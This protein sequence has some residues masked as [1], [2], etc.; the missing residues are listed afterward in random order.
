VDPDVSAL[1]LGVRQAVLDVGPVNGVDI[2]AQLVGNLC[3]A[4]E[5]VEQAFQPGELS[6]FYKRFTVGTGWHL[7]DS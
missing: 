7:G 4:V 1:I 6:A 5:H 2:D 3:R